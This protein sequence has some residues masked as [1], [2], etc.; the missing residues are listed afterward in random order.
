MVIWIFCLA[1]A[2]TILREMCNNLATS[3]LLVSLGCDFFP[4]VVNIIASVS[5]LLKER[6]KGR[7]N[8]KREISD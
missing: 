7:E 3:S 6:K 2:N 1:L 4:P 5:T 8:Y